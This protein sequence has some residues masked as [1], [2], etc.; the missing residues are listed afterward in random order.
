MVH[1]YRCVKIGSL[2]YMVV[3][4]NGAPQMDGLLQGKT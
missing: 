1:V 2:Q 3:S 4:I